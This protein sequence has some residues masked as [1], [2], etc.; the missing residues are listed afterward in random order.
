MLQEHFKLLFPTAEYKLR[1]S[2]CFCIASLCSAVVQ[3]CSTASR[4]ENTHTDATRQTLK[5]WDTEKKALK[6]TENHK[7]CP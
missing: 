2:Y 7:L 1:N 5:R 3:R 6:L 4:G